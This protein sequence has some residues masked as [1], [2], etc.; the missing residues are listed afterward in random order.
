M[1]IEYGN[2]WRIMV[3]DGATPEVFTALGGEVSFDWKRTSDKLD[4]STKDD[5]IYKSGSY[6]Q[7]EITISVNGKV[8]LPDT[9]FENIA[10]VAKTAP[11]QLNIQIAKGAI[12]K[13]EGEVGIGNFS[14]SFPANQPATYSFDMV[15][16]G[17]PVTDDLGASS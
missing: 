15:N 11:P 12:I 14:A 1:G 4:L 8:K 5:G 2:D 9:A 7:Q 17:A 13:F 3:G 10:D 16:V 6:G